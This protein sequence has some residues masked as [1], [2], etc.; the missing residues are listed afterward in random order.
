MSSCLLLLAWCALY[1]LPFAYVVF[2]L[3]FSLI[4]TL[5]LTL[6][7]NNTNT[8]VVVG[9]PYKWVYVLV[10]LLLYSFHV[11]Y[12]RSFRVTISI[13]NAVKN[14]LINCK[15]FSISFDE[16]SDINNTCEPIICL[17]TVHTNFNCFEVV[18]L[19]G[20]VAGQALF[21]ATDS[22]AF[23]FYLTKIN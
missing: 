21:D 10:W 17:K 5:I 20:Y 6:T 16:S 4:L 19:H 2:A 1:T 12:N 8:N 14:R 9:F 7:N 23:K 13:Y 22:K 3:V 18:S 11:N 15:Y